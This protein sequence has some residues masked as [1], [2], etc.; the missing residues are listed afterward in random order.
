MRKQLAV[1]TTLVLS[2]AC[3]FVAPAAPSQEIPPAGFWQGT[4]STYQFNFSFGVGHDY[5]AQKDFTSRSEDM[6]QL[7]YKLYLSPAGVAREELAHMNRTRSIEGPMDVRLLDYARGTAVVF[8]KDGRAVSGP[9]GPPV[10]GVV[11]GTR[12]ILGFTCEGKRY[13]WNGANTRLEMESWTPQDPGIR[14]P[15]LQVIYVSDERATLISMEVKVV[16]KLEP[17]EGLPASIFHLPGGIK[18][19][20]E[21]IIE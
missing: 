14:L 9:L 3:I 12:V 1:W 16:S 10:Q 4:Y 11:I 20:H 18:P 2:V 6:W 17:A 15:V 7:D 8:D 5:L 21:R 19:V 13:S